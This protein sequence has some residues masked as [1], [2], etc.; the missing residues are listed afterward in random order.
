MQPG[1]HLDFTFVI[2]GAANLATLCY[3]VSYKTVAN[4]LG[5]LLSAKFVVISY[6]AIEN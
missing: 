5:V 4:K 1:Q 2:L 3:T 6:A